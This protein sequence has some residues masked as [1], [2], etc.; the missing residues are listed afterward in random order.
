MS[1]VV[2]NPKGKIIVMTKGADSH[3]IPRLRRGQDKLINKTNLYLTEYANE[4]LR[5]LLLA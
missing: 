4:G 3:I 1:V 2:K 5:T